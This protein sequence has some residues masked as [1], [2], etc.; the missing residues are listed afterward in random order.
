MDINSGLYDGDPIPNPYNL[1]SLY[2]RCDMDYPNVLTGS[3]VYDLPFGHGRAFGSGWSGPVNALLGNWRLGGI[4]AANSGGPF[5]VYVPFDN[6]NTGTGGQTAQ[7][8]SAPVPSGFKQTRAAWFDYNAFGACAPYTFCDTGRNILRGP[9]R[10]NFDFSL[11][12]D[13]KFT[14]SKYLEFRAESFNI[15]NRVNF[16]SPGGGA[17]G[18]FTNFGGAA[19][20]SEGTPNYNAIFAA[21][22]A[23]EIQFALKLFF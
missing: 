2:G 15:F 1:R 7:Q 19:G 17:Q 3:T 10:V 14:E 20:V 8:I 18:S 13:F 12:K 11:Y 5:T 21:G 6:A 23:R 9:A 22:P 4:L 16:A